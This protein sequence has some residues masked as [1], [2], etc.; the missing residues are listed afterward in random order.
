MK[1]KALFALTAT[2]LLLSAPLLADKKEDDNLKGIKCMVSGKAVTKCSVAYKGGKVYFCCGKCAKAFKADLKK[3]A[4]DRKFTAKANQQ[5]YATKQAKLEKCVFTCKKLNPAT[6]TD[7]GG[8]KVCF[9]CPK[10]KKKAEG[11]DDPVEAV[12]NDK[13]FKNGFKVIAKKK[14]K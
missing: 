6:I 7:I 13:Q 8:T 5:L 3:D 4:K 1:L 12:F 10:C 2:A 14:T 11:A 9:C